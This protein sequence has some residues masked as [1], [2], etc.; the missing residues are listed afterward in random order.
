[1]YISSK[2][3]L[4]QKWYFIPIYLFYRKYFTII[5]IRVIILSIKGISQ[6]NE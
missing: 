1:M 4:S 6:I 5:N 2:H 3:I